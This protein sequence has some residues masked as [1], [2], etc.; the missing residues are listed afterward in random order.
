MIPTYR[1]LEYARGYITLGLAKQARDELAAIPKL[2]QASI[3][4]QELWVDVLMEL[5]AWKRVVRM[6]ALVCEKRPKNERS[7]IAW[8]YALREL[9]RIEEAQDVLWRAEKRY[10]QNSGVLH[11]NLACYA[12]LLGKHDEAEARLKRAMTMDESWREAAL[13]D[14][15]LKDLL[16]R[17]TANG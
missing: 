2:E 3:E 7:W 5:K 8:A 16:P 1:R 17:L 4:V 12:C 9:Q 10:G 15:D 6:A 11:Y 13:D 14:P